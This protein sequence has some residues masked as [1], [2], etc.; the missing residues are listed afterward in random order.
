L[1]AAVGVCPDLPRAGVENVCWPGFSK[2]SG[3][4]NKSSKRH[5]CF[6]RKLGEVCKKSAKGYLRVGFPDWLEPGDFGVTAGHRRQAPDHTIVRVDVHAAPHLACKGL[7]VCQRYRSLRRAADVSN[8]R[9]AGRAVLGDAS[10]PRTG[11]RWTGLANNAGVSAIKK[12][13]SPSVAVLIRFPSMTRKR[14]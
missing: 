1:V 3:V 11:G 10:N 12:G 4:L 5:R 2:R 14:C 6:I 7:G 8:H 13:N 9:I